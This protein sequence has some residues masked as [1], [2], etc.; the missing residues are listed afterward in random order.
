MIIFLNLVSQTPYSLGDPVNRIIANPMQTPPH[1]QPEWYFLFSYS[2]LR[3]FTSKTLGVISLAMSI[4]V[5]AFL[6]LFNFKFSS[7][8]RW[9]RHLTV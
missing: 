7:K 2:I 5:L 6:P 1:I 3:S 8:F 9:F 4:G